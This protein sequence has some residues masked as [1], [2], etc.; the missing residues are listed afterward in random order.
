[1]SFDLIGDG[2]V[3]KVG[4]WDDVHT[5]ID[6][7]V[8]WK[9]RHILPPHLIECLH[10]HGFYFLNDIGCPGTSMLLEQ[11]CLS[12]KNIGIVDIQDA[13]IWNGYII[14]LKASNV[15]L[16]DVVEELVW[17]QS[18]TG[19]YSPKDGYLQLI[20]DRTDVEIS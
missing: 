11:G 17:I 14:I 3:W 9:W 19:K 7:W 12:S 8:G 20:K 10:N 4:N 15:R 1:M 16:S 2:L 5:G 13:L 6:P 18:K